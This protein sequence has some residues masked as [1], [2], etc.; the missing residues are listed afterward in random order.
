MAQ[1][2]AP[3]PTA[4]PRLVANRRTIAGVVAMLLAFALLVSVGDPGRIAW[5]RTFFVIFG[6]L[7]IQAL[8]FVMLGATA[9]ALVEVFVPIGTLEKL[10]GLPRPLQ[11]PAAALAGVAFPIC[12]CGSVPV[13]RRLMQRGL[14]PSAAVTFMLA[15]PVLNPIVIAS[16]YVAFRGRTTLWTMVAGRFLLGMLVAIAVGWVIGNRSKDELLKPNPEEAHEHLLE[17]GRPEARWRRF[18]VHLGNDFLFMGRYLLLGATIAAAIQTFLPTSWLTSLAQRQVLSVLALMALAA[19]L[20][21]CSESD[22]FVAASF[23][24][25]GPAA[26]LGFLVFGP[27]VDMKLVAL[28]A[29]TFRRGFARTVVVVAGLATLVGALWVGIG[30]G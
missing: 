13:A 25:F 20:S 24:Q 28:Y 21:L 8:P 11:L 10:G 17:L 23:V 18:F 1:L 6:A 19:A 5:V 27:M 14:M 2:T 4:G 15:A 12:E 7:L 9:A 16:T 26:Q 3:A 29:G 30:F 22:A